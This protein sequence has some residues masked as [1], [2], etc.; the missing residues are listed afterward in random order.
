MFFVALYITVMRPERPQGVRGAASINFISHCSEPI[1]EPALP[2]RSLFGILTVPTY[3]LIIL[4]STSFLLRGRAVARPSCDYTVDFGGGGIFD[5]GVID[6]VDGIVG[7]DVALHSSFEN[8]DYLVS[9]WTSLA[10]F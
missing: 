10:T 8:S 7:N 4:H 5:N 9:I 2:K 6:E 1:I 3:H